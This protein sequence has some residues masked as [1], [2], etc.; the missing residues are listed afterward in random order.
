MCANMY[1]SCVCLYM[2]FLCFFWLFLF[3]FILSYSNL[4]SIFFNCY[5]LDVSLFSKE[6]MNMDSD[7]W[8]GGGGILGS[9]GRGNED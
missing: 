8:P 7:S 5:Y 3:L 2:S 6:I 9:W 1:D 4:F